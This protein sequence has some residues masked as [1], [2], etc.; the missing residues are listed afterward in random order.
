MQPLPCQPGPLGSPGRR[1]RPP[2]T[3]AARRRT[4]PRVR[5]RCLNTRLG[6]GRPGAPPAPGR[7]RPETQASTGGIWV[8]ALDLRQAEVSGPN[9][10]A[11]ATNRPT[12]GVDPLGLWTWSGVQGILQGNTEFGVPALARARNAIPEKIDIDGD[13]G[14]VFPFRPEGQELSGPWIG[15]TFQVGSTRNGQE[16]S[17]ETAAAA[18]IHESLHIAQIEKA[19]VEHRVGLTIEDREAVGRLPPGPVRRGRRVPHRG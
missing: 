1:R 19:L 14:Q 8:L 13:Y 2:P 6:R 7:A 4:R 10:Y 16:L 15:L 11:Y 5:P 18:Y 3:R 12:W 9:L 17:D